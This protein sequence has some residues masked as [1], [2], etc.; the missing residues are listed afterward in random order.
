MAL[1]FDFMELLHFFKPEFLPKLKSWPSKTAKM[2]GFFV[3]QNLPNLISRKIW[4]TEKVL[5]STLWQS[6]LLFEG[7]I[8]S[9]CRNFLKRNHQRNLDTFQCMAT[10]TLWIANSSNL[11]SVI[12]SI[13][14]VEKR[15]IY[16][17][18][19][20]CSVKSAYGVYT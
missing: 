20:K 5:I 15:E 18:L 13:H 1:N 19:K 7:F 8:E 11:I 4:V 17:R 2:A 12:F 14:S 3:T 10:K 16:P 9:L 6:I